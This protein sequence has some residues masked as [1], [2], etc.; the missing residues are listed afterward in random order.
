MPGYFLWSYRHFGYSDVVA[1]Y[2][3]HHLAWH[4]LPYWQNPIEYPVLIGVFMAAMAYLPGLAGYCWGTWIALAGAAA[5][6]LSLVERHVGP[7]AAWCW[8]LSPLLA[9]EGLLNWDLLGIVSLAVAY[10]AW[11]QRRGFFAGLAV[12]IGI[13]IKLFP[14]VFAVTAGAWWTARRTAAPRRFWT[15]LALGALGPN[16][17][18]ALGAYAGWSYFYSFNRL[19]APDPGLWRW[20]VHQHWLL[21]TQVDGLSAAIIGLGAVAFWW[22]VARGGMSPE[23][24]A[25]G[26]LAWG[27]AW[28]KVSS[29]QYGLWVYFGLVWL[30]APWWALAAFSAADVADWAAAF[31]WLALGTSHS[32]ATAAFAH[33]VVP[34]VIAAREAALLGVAVAGWG[35]GA[36]QRLAPGSVAKRLRATEAERLP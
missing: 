32:S 34:W 3:I 2:W 14:V 26:L 7:R 15:G 29:P 31:R 23:A 9:A 36:S 16:L 22:R 25:V 12:G 1:L 28:N 10:A 33:H 17:P 35:R 27:L 18:V 6:T 20:L 24:A 4:R 19:R 5:W 30:D 21:V 8:A 11:R 13:A